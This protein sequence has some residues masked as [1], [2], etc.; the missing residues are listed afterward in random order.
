MT[1][2][3][4]TDTVF[5]SDLL[6]KRCPELYSSITAAL[7]ERTVIYRLL[8][9]TNDIWC[10]DYMP[11]Q[12]ADN[13]FVF[14]KYSPDYL[15]TPYYSR[16]ITKVKAIPC[17]VDPL[18]ETF[19]NLDLILDGGNAVKCLDKVIMTEKV[20]FENK[21]KPRNE[22][23]RMLEEAF[24][25][26]IIFLPWDRQEI[27]GHSD[28]I[29]HYIGNNRVLMTN[30]ADFD[31]EM[32]K[33]FQRILENYFEVIPLRYNV[34]RKHARSWAY[35]NFLQVGKLVL[36]PQLGIPE[37][38]QALR[39]IADAM[40]QCE[41]VGIPAL[42]AVRKGGALN[43]ISW[44]VST[45]Q[46]GKEAAVC[47]KYDI[48]GH[49]VKNINEKEDDAEYQNEMGYCYITGSYVEKDSSKAKAW[50][51][52]S[53]AQGLALAQFNLGLLYLNGEDDQKD[54]S[55]AMEWFGKAAEQGDARAQLFLGVC[56]EEKHA[57]DEEII[58]AYKKAADM[59]SDEAQCE[60]GFWYCNGERGLEK[61]VAESNRWFLM[62]A[63][64]GHDEAQFQMGIKYDKGIGVRKNH[65]EALKWF[66]RA[67]S[68]ENIRALY[69][70]GRCY[71]YGD[72]VC[73]DERMAFYCLRRSAERGYPPAMC[74]V[75]DFYCRG[76]YR[77]KAVDK[78]DE[79]AVK[80]YKEAVA[81]D[82]TPALYK[83]GL[84]YYYGYGLP[85]DHGTALEYF[86]KAAE[87][88]YAD[89]IYTIGDFYHKGIVVN[90]DENKAIEYYER[91]AELGN[92]KAKMKM[93]EISDEKEKP[94]KLF[95]DVPF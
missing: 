30:Y 34:K 26:A 87:E 20:F 15:N 22:I 46:W 39:Q 44:N 1:T 6:P 91:A 76:R 11:I 88:E 13:R 58:A 27:M 79:Q 72:G 95:E 60:L 56:L 41:V 93:K 35:V 80:W 68:K 36:V 8:P 54:I 53:A 45:S 86:R 90:K 10:R 70:I 50:F 14:Y 16:T 47:G 17:I 19:Y 40:P 49:P 65:K 5:F 61:N 7:D 52:K 77:S 4:R 82:Y 85:V 83:L 84:C 2:D 75:G 69:M 66:K 21:N 3:H 81:K 12:T 73:V 51:D 28:G 62:A 32:A 57:S 37:D 42:E 43:C 64:N 63:N 74:M 92:D 55:M 59:G 31:A 24:Q 23:H 33:R 25:C 78:D 71:Y 67:S 38:E 9:N 89:A 29:V 48:L 94:R 18:Q